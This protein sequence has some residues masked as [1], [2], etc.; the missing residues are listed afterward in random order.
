[1]IFLKLLYAQSFWKTCLKRHSF[2]ATMIDLKKTSLFSDD[3]NTCTFLPWISTGKVIGL[4]RTCITWNFLHDEIKCSE[5]IQSHWYRQI[6]LL[7][8]ET[9]CSWAH[10]N[11]HGSFCICWVNLVCWPGVSVDGPLV[12]LTF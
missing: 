8:I 5:L 3:L 9:Q 10:L 2:L 7:P 12:Y 4:V 11:M 6:Q 1:M